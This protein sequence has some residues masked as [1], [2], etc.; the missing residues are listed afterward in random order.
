M[1]K[2]IVCVL[3]MLMGVNVWATREVLREPI[4]GKTARLYCENNSL[5]M[6]LIVESKKTYNGSLDEL[7]EDGDTATLRFVGGSPNE[8]KVHVV[9]SQY[10][11][12]SFAWDMDELGIDVIN[13]DLTSEVNWYDYDRAFAAVHIPNVGGAGSPEEKAAC[14]FLN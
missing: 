1:K 9:K 4:K 12:L 3:M 8:V 14:H 2:Y 7:F 11:Q 10:G 13:V 5:N 6:Y